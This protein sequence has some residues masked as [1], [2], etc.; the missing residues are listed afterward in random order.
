MLSRFYKFYLYTNIHVSLAAAALC[1]FTAFLFLVPLDRS[2]LIFVFFAT[3]FSYGAHRIFID[4]DKIK[5][6]LSK[7]NASLLDY[8]QH[9]KI[10]TL[11]SAVIMG[12]YFFQLS[13]FQQISLALVGCITLLYIAPIFPNGRRLR[14][15]SFLKIIL[16]SF[17]WM[18]V[19]YTIRAIEVNEDSGK[20][21]R[22]SIDR[23]LF[24][25]A[26]TIPFDIRDRKSDL[27]SGTKTL[28]TSFGINTSKMLS[29]FALSVASLILL[30]SLFFD[31]LSKSYFIA[32]VMTYIISIPL[33]QTADEEKKDVF[34]L[35]IL[36]GL[37]LL[38]FI[39]SLLLLKV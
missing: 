16:I 17:V 13:Y 3:L 24:I 35:G 30:Y 1:L 27:L 39:F 25:F 22:L 7:R 10:F 21:L 9:L 4:V 33:I 6:Q 19:T 36:D 2:Y 5:H 14:D 20:I 29:Y 15:F 18:A 31:Q 12:M 26:I 38:P 34:Y 37:M 32:A 23:F 8:Q 11:F 28:V